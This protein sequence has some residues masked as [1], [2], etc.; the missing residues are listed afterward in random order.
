MKRSIHANVWSI[1]GGRKWAL[2]YSALQPS[3]LVG[4]G[5]F[6]SQRVDSYKSVRLTTTTTT[7]IKVYVF[8]AE[9][10][11]ARTGWQMGWDYPFSINGPGYKRVSR[12]FVGAPN[13][14]GYRDCFGSV[15]SIRRLLQVCLCMLFVL[16]H[17]QTCEDANLRNHYGY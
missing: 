13:R 11:V 17:F 14:S 9:H 2:F 8:G 1:F 16:M 3:Q 6:W 7:A 15:F 12:S 4:A 10:L 5:R